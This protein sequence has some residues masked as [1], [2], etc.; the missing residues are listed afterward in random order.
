MMMSSNRRSTA[1]R[2]S[3]RETEQQEQE[4]RK[5][6][7]R[8]LGKETTPDPELTAV[9]RAHISVGRKKKNKKPSPVQD[10]NLSLPQPIS[11]RLKTLQTHSGESA[12]N[13][14]Q[15][16][17][18]A[19]NPPTSLPVSV[20]GEEV[21][22][23]TGALKK[24]KKK[25]KKAPKKIT[26]TNNP[27]SEVETELSAL[28]NEP[29]KGD[30]HYI[31]SELA[32]SILDEMEEQTEEPVHIS[33]AL[34]A[35]LLNYSSIKPA[36][37]LNLPPSVH[38]HAHTIMPMKTISFASSPFG[39]IAFDEDSFEVEEEKSERSRSPTPETDEQS[40]VREDG[41]LYTCPICQEPDLSEIKLTA[42]VFKNHPKDKHTK[43]MVC[44]ICSTKA[45]GDP[46]FLSKDFYGHLR[47]RHI[48]QPAEPQR[49][50]RPNLI[51]RPA[52]IITRDRKSVV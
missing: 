50:A 48:G 11:K 47:L 18:D 20:H 37:Q 30:Q 43:S 13:L 8:I 12:G 31:P 7:I 17:V 24:K 45:G 9:S 34:A 52:D 22:P 3:R 46:N 10:E 1:T 26:K 14:S 49:I 15:E 21:A 38:N 44:P 36:P 25:K 40:S 29:T 19:H 39:A 6:S 23:A 5:R 16:K 2:P 4:R 42:H 28:V 33:S 32:E 27:I 41:Q 51:F 35:S